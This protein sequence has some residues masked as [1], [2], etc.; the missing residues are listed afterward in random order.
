MYI[1]FEFSPI[2]LHYHSEK[3][4]FIGI[5]V[6]STH[7][8]NNIILEYDPEKKIN[9]WYLP[10]PEFY[11]PQNG[12]SNGIVVGSRIL[13]TGICSTIAYYDIPSKTWWHRG[14]PLPISNGIRRVALGRWIVHFL[15]CFH[16]NYDEPYFIYDTENEVWFSSRISLPFKFY[17]DQCV[18]IGSRRLVFTRFCERG[19]RNNRLVFT[20]DRKDI[21]P[22]WFIIKDY[23]LLRKLVDTG[24]AYAIDN[25]NKTEHIIQM[26]ITS[27]H[28]DM[29]N[30]IFSFL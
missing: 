14:E 16:P 13:Y 5:I 30:Y 1:D 17:I 8:I 28:V 27:F 6:S 25:G 19:T 29:F 20:V 18:A 21:I 15:Y 23:I 4:V 26:F 3:I 9:H 24:R 11:Q 22:N 10:P 7:T 12:P 2:S